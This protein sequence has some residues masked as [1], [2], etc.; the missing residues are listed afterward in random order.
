MSTR[1][2]APDLTQLAPPQLIE[3]VSFEAIL[4]AQKAWVLSQWDVVRVTR[5]DL[6][7]IDTLG[8]ETEPMT[9]VLQS[10]AY[11][12]TIIRALIN[13]K[14]RAVLLAYAVG[15]DLDHL[16][17]LFGTVRMVIVPATDTVPVIMESDDRFRRRIQLAPEA[18]STVGP[19]GAY[20]YFA[21]TESAEVMDAWAYSP[22]DGRVNV[23][24]AGF[25]GA[26]VSDDVMATLM[27]RFA[28]EDTVPLT[29]D[30][31]VMRAARTDYSVAIVAYFSRG[32]DPLLIKSTIETAVRN[33]ATMNERIG[34]TIYKSGLVSV[35]RI[36]AID[37]VVI[38]IGDVVCNDDH[39]PHLLGVT[40][41]TVVS[42]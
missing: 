40:I 4:T 28:M 39:I 19:R 42:D 15:T 33:Y 21:L 26:D 37:N 23:V 32:P 8:L 31:N 1:F 41:E 29:D 38:D 3:E 35:A 30:V 27:R 14:A 18:F 36:P 7:P 16:G 2:L 6:P 22:S 11:R 12:E 25:N 13:D 34:A 20:I 9:I 10:Y 17:V 24:V 5:P